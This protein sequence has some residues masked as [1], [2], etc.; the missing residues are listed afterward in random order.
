MLQRFDFVFFSL[1]KKCSYTEFFLVRI[2]SEY[3][4]IRTGVNS[5]FEHFSRG[6]SFKLPWC[7]YDVISFFRIF[8][9]F[10]CFY[11][12]VP[13]NMRRRWVKSAKIYD[14]YDPYYLYKKRII[15]II[16]FFSFVRKCWKII[17][18]GGG[19]GWGVS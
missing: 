17:K 10:F 9:N 12:E 19:G 1:R 15:S 7:V 5:V 14:F 2:Q 16:L 18:R 3:R 6:V 4:K 13:N 11:S 8:L